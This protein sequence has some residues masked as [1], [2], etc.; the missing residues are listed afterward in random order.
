MINSREYRRKLTFELNF[1][2]DEEGKICHPEEIT[3][4]MT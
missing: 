3:T 4:A 2:G 1:E